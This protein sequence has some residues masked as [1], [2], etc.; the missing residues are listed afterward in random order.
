MAEWFIYGTVSCLIIGLFEVVSLILWNDFYAFTKPF[1]LDYS[2]KKK[3]ILSS[4]LLFGYGT[5]LG[6]IAIFFAFT[7][8]VLFFHKLFKS[9]EQAKRDFFMGVVAISVLIGIICSF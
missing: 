8:L 6:K 9:D 5:S 2:S 7:Y 4:I 3:L 1:L